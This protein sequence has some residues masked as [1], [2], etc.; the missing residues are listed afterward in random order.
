LAGELAGERRRRSNDGAPAGTRTAARE[1]AMLNNALPRELPCSL[2]KTPGRSPSPEDRR[3]GELGGGGRGNSGSGD[4]AAWL[5]QHA[6]RGAT[7]VHKEELK[8]SWEWGRRLE[9]GA[10]RRRQWWDDGGSGRMRV[11]ARNG[12]G[13]LIS[14]RE[15]G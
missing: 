1:E 6:A 14:A 7:G 3:R 4:R 10:H 8:R 2:E 11:R 12:R 9:G 15:V 13:W 5:D